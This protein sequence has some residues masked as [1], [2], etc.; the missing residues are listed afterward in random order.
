MLSFGPAAYTADKSWFYNSP[1]THVALDDAKG[2]RA[3]FCNMLAERQ[4][5]LHNQG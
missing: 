5:R 3:L 2:Q 1:H 4:A